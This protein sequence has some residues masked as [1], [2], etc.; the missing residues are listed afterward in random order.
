MITASQHNNDKNKNKNSVQNNN[1]FTD[2]RLREMTF[3]D[4]VPQAVR[5][6]ALGGF[7]PP[8]IR[9]YLEHVDIT[10]DAGFVSTH[11]ASLRGLPG[12]RLMSYRSERYSKDLVLTAQDDG[13]RLRCLAS[14]P[15]VSSQFTVLQ[16]HVHCKIL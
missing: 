2:A 1:V 8:F 14:I 10:E 9:V 13:K 6:V 16:V 11:A 7:P 15:E 4:G 12:L 3:L 5:C